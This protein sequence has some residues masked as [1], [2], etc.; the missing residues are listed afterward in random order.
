[1]TF[2]KELQ[3]RGATVDLEEKGSAHVEVSPLTAEDIE[4]AI[5][6]VKP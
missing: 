4:R 1:M 6:K 5:E 2:V 3:S